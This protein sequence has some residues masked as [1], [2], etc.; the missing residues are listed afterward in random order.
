[1][2]E[3]EKKMSTERPRRFTRRELLKL[4]GL[5]AVTLGVGLLPP[6]ARP[7][8]DEQGIYVPE[9][10]AEEAKL[11]RILKF[12]GQVIEKN[13]EEHNLVLRVPDP[14]EEKGY[15]DWTFTEKDYT[16]YFATPEPFRL[17]TIN[18]VRE[19]GGS[20]ENIKEGNVVVVDVDWAHAG[21]AALTVT[22]HPK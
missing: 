20:W 14:K 21:N 11:H 18:K 2:A 12:S 22:V 10:H 1:M 7:G 8:E 6:E 13:D 15:R 19:E 9:V 3:E 5:T 16:R 4:G 17:R